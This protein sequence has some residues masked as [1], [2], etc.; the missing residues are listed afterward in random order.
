M[1]LDIENETLPEQEVVE[2][3]YLENE[4]GFH[5]FDF[6]PHRLLHQGLFRVRFILGC[7]QDGNLSC[8]VLCRL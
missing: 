3:K 5:P 4:L 6:L 2:V 1:L 7:F 8:V